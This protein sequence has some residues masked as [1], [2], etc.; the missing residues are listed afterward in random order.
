M[1]LMV[2]FGGIV[3]AL[4]TETTFDDINDSVTQSWSGFG[5]GD[6]GG[7]SQPPNSEG[8]TSPVVPVAPS[9]TATS[10]A[11]PTPAPT[12]TAAAISPWTGFAISRETLGREMLERLSDEEIACIRSTNSESFY[13]YFETLP[14]GVRILTNP[15]VRDVSDLPELPD[16]LTAEST[17]RFNLA[18]AQFHDPTAPTPIPT[19][20]PIQTPTPEPAPAATPT[21]L[22]TPTVEPTPT[23]RPTA[24]P[25][26]IR[27]NARWI[28]TLELR[29]HELVNEQRVT[30]LGFDAA[31]ASIARSHSADMANSNYFSHTNLR[32]QS[33]S[34][35]GAEVGYDCRKDYG[36][37]YTYGL[38]EN[39]YQAWLYGQSWTLN[40]IVVR[41]DYYE[42]EE[43]AAL[44]VDG[45]M[46]SAGHR[47][48]ILNGSYDLQGIGVAVNGDEQVYVTQNFC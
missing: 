25:A 21:P 19:S 32:G 4:V 3:V 14:L 37:Y 13:E 5:I 20:A 26:L 45:W 38:A 18:I 28:A 6:M 12:A 16:C 46:D 42:L 17:M 47:E 33:P 40:G 29:I 39:I 24:T 11:T 9:P 22:P 31:L 35:R 44:V 10:T 8:P 15:P 7:E 36:S 1:V 2:V 48:N 41:K 34:D 30:A 27:G 23:P 43:L